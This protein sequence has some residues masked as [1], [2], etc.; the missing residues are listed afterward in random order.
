MTSTLVPIISADDHVQE[1]PNVWVD[2]MPQKFLDLAPRVERLPMGTQAD[3][4]AGRKYD[5]PGTEGPLVDYWF[6]D[7]MYWGLS[8]TWGAAGATG[9]EIWDDAQLTYDE[10]RPGCYQVKER[11][12]DMD[13]NG[14]EASVC[15]PNYSR[16][17]GQR[18]S[19]VKDRDLG[20]ACIQAY[21]DWMIEEWAGPSG[22]RL[23][24]I[25]LIPL[26]DAELAAAE[27][28]RNAARG[29][30]AVCFSE[31]PQVLGFPSINRG[32]WDPLF[33]ACEETET[34]LSM[35]I[36]SST[37]MFST[38]PDTPKQ[39]GGGTGFVNSAG[40]LSEYLCSGVFDRFP[41]L[42]IF[43][44]ESQVGWIP[45]VLDRLDDTWEVRYKYSDDATSK[46]P[47]EIY[48]DHVFSCMF[49]DKVG[50]RVLD[51][52]GEDQ[53]MFESDYPHSDG[54]WPHSRDRANLLVGG[55]TA[56]QQYKVLRGTAIKLFKLPLDK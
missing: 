45:F 20:F 32:F 41:G 22:G 11:L 6:F 25:G 43:Y 3:D 54:T 8:R 49:K 10:I 13:I 26:W 44:A 42:K 24:P 55:L 48:K 36:G 9:Q 35:H 46:P 50:V 15:F 2:R 14:V 30:P 37:K 27:V 56:E 16:F 23:I 17:A 18:F 33:R 29:F 52:I 4:S 12:E 28:R 40:S 5:I 19:E 38:G 39:A 47:S 53:I 1:P 7:D 51:L 34:V 21:N 31:L